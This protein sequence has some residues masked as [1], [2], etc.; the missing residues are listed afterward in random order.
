MSNLH[1]IIGEDDY[2]VAEVAKKIIGD[3]DGLEVI[4]S[5]T[6]TNAESQLKDLAAAEMSFKTPPFLE[7]K[8]VTW[9][10]NVHFLPSGGGKRDDNKRATSEEVKEALEKFAKLIAGAP[11]PENQHF[12]LSGPR[13]LQSSIVAKTLASAAEMVVLTV[14]SPKEAHQAA[15]V[16]VIDRAKELGMSF[17]AGAAEKFVDAVGF[18]TRALLNELDKMRDYLGKDSDTI[19][20]AAI[21]EVTAAGPMDDPPFWDFTDAVASRNLDLA[22]R[23]LRAFE[24]SGFAVVVTIV[25]ERLFRQLL[26]VAEN[27]PSALNG[28]ALTKMKNFAHNWS[29]SEL[30]RARARF[31]TLRERVVSGFTSG[32]PLIVATLVRILTAKSTRR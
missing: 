7:P 3:G 21:S 20:S 1:V 10:K 5:A 29:V 14:K 19:T 9:W 13:M 25:L 2:L 17:A 28:Y 18:D 32:E 27:R 31:I 6:S 16:R 23:E 30:R 26:E 11:L 24:G 12:I 22:L 8:K 4:D 15:V